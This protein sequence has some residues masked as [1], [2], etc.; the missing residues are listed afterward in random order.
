KLSS[1]MAHDF[2]NLLSSIFGSIH[3]LRSRIPE[4]ENVSKLIDN[5]ES[6][7]VRARDLTKGLLSFGKPT[8]KRKEVVMPN[9]LLSEISKVVSQTFPSNITFEKKIDEDLLNLLGNST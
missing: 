8:A 3:L 9:F 5:I 7:S 1:G 2:N 6:C 4:S